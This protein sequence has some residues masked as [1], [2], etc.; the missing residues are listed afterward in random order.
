MQ[1]EVVIFILTGS[2]GIYRGADGGGRAGG[3]GT[4]G[5]GRWQKVVGLVVTYEVM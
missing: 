1:G 5:D 3:G 2:L 4:V